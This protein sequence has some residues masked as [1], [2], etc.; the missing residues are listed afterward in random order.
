MKMMN[1]DRDADDDDD[2]DDFVLDVRTPPACTHVT[3]QH[4]KAD[5][6]TSSTESYNIKSWPG[7]D[8]HRTGGPGDDEHRPGNG[9]IKK[10]AYNGPALKSLPRDD[11][12]PVTTSSS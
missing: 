2:D 10:L 1:D 6:G 8:E 5:N 4:G 11:G 3:Q 9:R 7:D 12:R